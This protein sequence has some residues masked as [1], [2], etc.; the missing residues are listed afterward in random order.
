M[1]SKPVVFRPAAERDL[2]EIWLYIAFDNP[3]AADAV[4]DQIQ[5]R[6]QQLSAFPQ[7]GR[8]RPE[9][10]ED[11]RSV[12]VGTYLILYRESENFIDI[13]RVVHGARDLTALF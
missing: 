1:D 2:D 9:I 3:A 5:K 4:V 10:A 8:L 6:T 11:A 7:T 13:V 12:P